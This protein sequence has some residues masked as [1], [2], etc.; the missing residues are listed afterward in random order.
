MRIRVANIMMLLTFI[1]CGY[2]IFSGKKAVEQGE[3][4]LKQ[5]QDWHAEYNQKAIEEAK[6]KAQK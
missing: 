6:S 3:S 1:G 2:M 4:V 5:N